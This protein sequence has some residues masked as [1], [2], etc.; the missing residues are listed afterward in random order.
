[1]W[2]VTALSMRIKSL[3]YIENVLYERRCL[4]SGLPFSPDVPCSGRDAELVLVSLQRNVSTSELSPEK[5]LAIETVS[6]LL[7]SLNMYTRRV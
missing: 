5:L 6:V 3:A 2:P 4:S 7:V 1:M